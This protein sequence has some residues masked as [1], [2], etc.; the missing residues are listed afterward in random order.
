MSVIFT[1]KTKVNRSGS[2]SGVTER[3]VKEAEHSSTKT[4]SIWWRW[5]E[6]VGLLHAVGDFVRIE[7]T[8]NTEGYIRILS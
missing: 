7:M 8:M 1:D 6:D 5:G 3:R 2:D 4:G